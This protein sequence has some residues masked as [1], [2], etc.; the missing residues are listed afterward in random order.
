MDQQLQHDPKTK[1]Q[2][3]EALYAHLY[4][5]VDSKFQARIDAII[6]KNSIL[7]QVGHRSFL[8]KG[9]LYSCDSSTPPRKPNRLHPSLVPQM[10][11]YLKD[12][13]ALNEREIPYVLNAINMVL[14][15][16]NDLHDYLR[17]LPESM[18]PPIEK[19]I[20]TCP[21][22]T[23]KLSDEAVNTFKQ[24]HAEAIQKMRNRMVMNLII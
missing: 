24:S 23:K 7:T 2:I 15:A 10:E 13:K 1:K 21:C 14:N 12:T 22:R 18:H 19:L 6:I 20:S 17:L 16:S 5:P 4:N 11:E 8:Y 9:Q 3:K